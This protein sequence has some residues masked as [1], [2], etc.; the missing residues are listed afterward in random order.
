MTDHYVRRAN[1]DLL[2]AIKVKQQDDDIA[3]DMRDV[4][5]T[6][7]NP[8]WAVFAN[9]N[10]VIAVIGALELK[11]EGNYLDLYNRLRG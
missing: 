7:Y 11:V 10:P 8:D 1:G 4:T 3:D 5:E 6:V 2:P 9:S